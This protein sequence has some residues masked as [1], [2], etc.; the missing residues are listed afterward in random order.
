MPTDA[1]QQPYVI[2]IWLGCACKPGHLWFVWH[3][4]FGRYSLANIIM[5]SA[6]F[7]SSL[8][9]VLPDE[10]YREEHNPF[11]DVRII[12]PLM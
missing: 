9:H 8:K 10:Y 1:Y 5:L 4:E 3:I 2:L 12:K 11:L 6:V 7:L